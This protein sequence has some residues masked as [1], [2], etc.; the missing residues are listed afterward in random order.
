VLGTRFGP[1]GEDPHP[2]R[3]GD[4]DLGGAPRGGGE[5]L[6]DDADEDVGA[7]DLVVQPL[8]PHLADLHAVQVPCEENTMPGVA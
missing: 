1:Q 8:R 3:L 7:S 4:A 2:V 6:G 5:R